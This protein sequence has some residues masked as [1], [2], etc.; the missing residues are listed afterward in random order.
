M[1]LLR[2]F[3]FLLKDVTRMYALNFG[4]HATELNLNLAQCRVLCYIERNQGISQVRLAYLADIDPMTLMRILNRMEEDGLIE[5]RSDP[6]D[7]RARQLF[8]R[9]SALPVLK[10][11]WRISDRARAESL[12]GLSAGDREQLMTL[13]QRIRVNLDG[14][15]PGASDTGGTALPQTRKRAQPRTEAPCR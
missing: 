8:L 1:E 2:N 12:S 7:R 14:L 15:M 13:L 5:R 3:G 11:I 4:R 6:A 9:A 10:E